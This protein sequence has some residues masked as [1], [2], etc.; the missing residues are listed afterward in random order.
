MNN[1]QLIEIYQA[2][3]NAKDKPIT[4][5]NISTALKC[6]RLLKEMDNDL[7]AFEEV[8]D[9][10]MKEENE[11]Q[12]KKKIIALLETEAT[13]KPGT[14]TTKEILSIKDLGVEEMYKIDIMIKE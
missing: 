4:E 10:I 9:Q 8:R 6:V 12:K 11:E 2:L 1:Q 5:E 13:L 3:R 14:F 7:K